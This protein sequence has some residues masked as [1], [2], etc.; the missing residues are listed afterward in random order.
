MIHTLPCKETMDCCHCGLILV[1]PTH[2]NDNFISFQH[3]NL[4]V[5]KIPFSVKTW[6]CIELQ[7][8]RAFFYLIKAMV[9]INI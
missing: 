4:I 7:L 8:P 1:T 2:S 3:V 6:Q 5:G 9:Y